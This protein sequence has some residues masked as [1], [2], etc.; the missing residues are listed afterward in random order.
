MVNCPSC[1]EENP[2]KFRLCGYCGTPLVAASVLPV[3]EV[4]KTVTVLFS[5]LKDSTALGERLDAEALHEVKERYFHAMAAEIT[6]HGGKIEKYIGDAI[7]AVFGLPRAHE[8]DAL[9]AVRAAVGM[10]SVLAR[11]NEDLLLRYGVALANRTGV[12][13]GEV[14]ANIVPGADQKLATGDAVNVAAR[15]EQAASANQIYIGD[16][17][18]RLVRDAVVVDAVEPLQLKGKAERVAAYQLVSVQGLE[19]NVRR[20]DTPVV[21]RDDELAALGLAY[22]EVSETRAARLVT[23]IGDAGAGKSRL[24]VEVVERIA[25][26]AHV[27]RGRCLPYG[28][29]ITFWPLVTM[30]R[31][32]AGIRADDSTEVARSKL[33]GLV[34]EPE[35]ADRL[36]SATGLSAETFPMLELMWAARKFLETLASQ[37]PVV[38]V[39]DDIHWAE[40][41]FLELLEHVLDASTGAPILLL[42][43]ARH[44]LLEEHPEWGERA[45]STRI[46]L[47]PLSD[48]ASAQVIAN[49]VGSADLPPEVVGRIVNA[50][51]GN[52]LYVEH[53]LSM[54]IDSGALQ[55]RDGGWVRSAGYTEIAVPPTIHALLEARLDKLSRDERAAI[56]PASVIGLEFARPAVE[57]LSH[58]SDPVVVD[59]RLSSLTHRRFIR[60]VAEREADLVYRFHHHLVRETVYNTLLKRARATLHIEFVRWADRVNAE[61][62]R[63]L[64]F[65]EILGYHLEQAYHYLAELGPLDEAGRAIGNDAARRLGAAGR[66][67]FVRADMHA[68]V[69]LLQRAVQ[70]VPAQD[71]IRLALLPEL[72]E[73]LMELGEFSRAR[74]VLEEAETIASQLSDH[75]LGA[76]ARIVGMFVKLYSGE[77]GN[78]GAD[79]L[80]VAS[81]AV[82]LLEAANAHDALATA[83]RLVGLVHGVAGRYGQAGDATVRY[84]NH[85]RRAGNERLTARSAMGLSLNALFGPTC[86]ID[87][88]AQCETIV[89][90]GLGDREVESIILCVLAQLRAM[91]GEFESARSFYRKGRAMLRELGQGVIAASTGLDVAR[92]E[93]LAGDLAGAER[94]VRADY[95]FLASKGETYFLATLAALLARIVRAQ[96]RDAEAL[97]LSVAAEVAAAADDIDAQSLWRSVRAPILARAGDLAQAEALARAAVDLAARTE[98][99]I[100]QAEARSE[101][102]EVLRLAGK[103]DEARQAMVEATAL[104]FSKGDIVS[105]ER[106]TSWAER[107]R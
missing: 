60:P 8:D 40:K 106:S 81:E 35:V 10:R 98:A 88:I 15:L 71:P 73:G 17:T 46:V 68:A 30:L 16:I 77:Q 19:G 32:A 54:L 14:V 3:H 51:E 28:D 90:E 57:A 84:R 37:G 43:T 79:A 33:L 75:A 91:N 66:R 44:D 26:N 55:Q 47:R 45:S 34:G 61:R 95:E 62:G 6:R 25:P 83:W 18:Y 107:L 97:E 41:A 72:G 67:A 9:R 1:G 2:P 93:L 99:P 52:P 42:T 12:N 7:M 76:E 53:M 49:L 96:N 59:G 78:W 82:P 103:T 102:A 38:A 39:I 86:A 85:A 21:G 11:V 58:E 36:A 48:G 94:E 31:E 101:L 74:A 92:T 13:T 65:Q 63:G 100:L 4:R 104:Y 27:V 5:D 22:R 24:V 64:E 29:G 20:I 105:T 89:A 87:A 80:R 69:N 56:E 50:A 23:V 70:L